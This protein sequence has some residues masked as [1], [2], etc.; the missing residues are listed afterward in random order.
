[1]LKCWGLPLVHIIHMHKPMQIRT[2]KHTCAEK[3]NIIKTRTHVDII[4][5]LEYTHAVTH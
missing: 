3:K 4:T 2:Y 1:M 5:V